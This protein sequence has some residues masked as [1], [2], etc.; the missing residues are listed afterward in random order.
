MVE[1]VDRGLWVFA[2]GLN[3]RFCNVRPAGTCLR[4]GVVFLHRYD[5]SAGRG[6]SGASSAT[7]SGALAA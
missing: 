1:T 6:A 3:E 4:R 2:W 5:A 7:V